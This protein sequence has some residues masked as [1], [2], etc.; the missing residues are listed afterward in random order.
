MFSGH[1]INGSLLILLSSLF[2]FGYL[3][4]AKVNYKQRYKGENK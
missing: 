1:N 4:H 2:T 3:F